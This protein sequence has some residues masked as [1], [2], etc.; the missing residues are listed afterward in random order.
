MLLDRP[1]NGDVIQCYLF[2]ASVNLVCKTIAQ[3]AR[4]AVERMRLEMPDFT[5]SNL[6][7]A[8][9]SCG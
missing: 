2:T 9:Q 6:R 3:C 7:A 1:H 8:S 4:A 5:A